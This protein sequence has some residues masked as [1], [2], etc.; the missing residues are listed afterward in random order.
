LTGL[1][2]FHR[3][4]EPLMPGVHRAAAPYC[5]RCELGLRYPSCA[6]ACADELERIV[7]EVGAERIGAFIAEPVQGVG[8]VIV[9]PPGYFERIREICERHEILFI[10]DEVITGFGR[11]GRPFGIQHV[12]RVTPDMLVFA[13]GVTSGY[14]PLGGVF[15]LERLYQ[16]L[17]DAGEGFV[18]HQGFT[19][20]G[21]PVACA[22]GLANL[23]ILARE[24]LLRDVKSKSAHLRRLLEQLAAHRIV[25][26]IRCIGLM[27]AVE[28][29]RDR[30][31]REPFPE[32]QRVA[33]RIRQSA[34]RR[35]VI[36][37][38]SGELIALCPPLII[39]AAEIGTIVEALG[40]AIA[41]VQ[42]ELDAPASRRRAAGR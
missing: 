8:G 30:D 16:T 39:T 33:W 14:V 9:P 32:A 41:E 17:L 37:R 19:Y 31:R 40:G 5:Y 38:A 42:A 3:Y 15:L 13:K 10:A 28:I 27:A 36:L 22:A 29:V 24:N 25:G 7:A 11:L 18:L 23:D 35:G 2:R 1:E 12:S 21:H 20:S 4:Y 34:L 6:L 26:E